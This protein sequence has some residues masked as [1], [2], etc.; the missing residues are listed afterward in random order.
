MTPPQ[1]CLQLTLTEGTHQLTLN[2]VEAEPQQNQ[3]GSNTNASYQN[4]GQI[5]GAEVRQRTGDTGQQS[6]HFDSGR[7]LKPFPLS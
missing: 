7:S 5:T 2:V 6:V 4:L 1:Y 3:T